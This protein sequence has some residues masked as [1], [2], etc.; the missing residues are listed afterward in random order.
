M[1]DVSCN[2]LRAYSASRRESL[3]WKNNRRRFKNRKNYSQHDI[4]EKNWNYFFFSTITVQT[5]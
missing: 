4:D 3:F 2:Q 1:S 5:R